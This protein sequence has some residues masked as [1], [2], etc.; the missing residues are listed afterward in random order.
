MQD[1]APA[2][3]DLIVESD[4]RMQ[5]AMISDYDTRSDS[6][7]GADGTSCTYA[8][9]LSNAGM[10][11]NVTARIHH[12]SRSDHSRPVNEW[13]HRRLRIQA[14]NDA[15]EGG[16]GLCSTDYRT[17]SGREIQRNYQTSRSRNV[18]L[19]G[20]LPVAYERRVSTSRRL[21]RSGTG[22][23]LFAITFKR[24]SQQIG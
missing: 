22:D 6:A 2:K 3:L 23:V 9:I 19:F 10:R 11:S 18:S 8:N 1:A 17:A 24:A 7:A 4:V 16:A 13:E 12:G 15:G 5:H 21:K 20:S 14:S